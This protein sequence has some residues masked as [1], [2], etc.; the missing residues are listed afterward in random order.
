MHALRARDHLR[1]LGADDGLRA[2]WL[3]E[4]LALLDPPACGAERVGQYVYAA[5]GQTGVRTD[6]RHSSTTRRWLRADAEHMTQRSWLKLLCRQV[7][8]GE[9]TIGWGVPKDDE[10]AIA[11]GPERVADRYPDVVE[12][13]IGCAGGRG[14]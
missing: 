6:L 8:R 13:D 4:R 2:E 10:D 11:L 3:A 7:S 1:E 9:G 5:G 14:V 12:G